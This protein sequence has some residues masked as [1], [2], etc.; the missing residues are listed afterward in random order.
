MIILRIIFI[1]IFLLVGA[2]VICLIPRGS[3]RHDVQHYRGLPFAHRGLH[4]R[5]IPENSMPAFQA[6]VDRGLA[7]ELDIHLTKDK[8]IIKTLEILI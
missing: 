8:I 5:T 6:A 1:I 7:I 3:R 2:Y 4:T